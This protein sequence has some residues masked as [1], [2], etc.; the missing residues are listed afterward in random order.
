MVKFCHCVI[1]NTFVVWLDKAHRFVQLHEPAFFVFEQWAEGK[2]Q[3]EIGKSCSDRYHLPENE[4]SRFVREIIGETE[5]LFPE[6]ETEEQV[7]VEI[8]SHRSPQRIY[9]QHQCRIGHKTITFRYGDEMIAEQFQPIFEQFEN[10][11]GI[12]DQNKCESEDERSINLYTSNGDWCI[13]IEGKVV[14]SYHHDDWDH[15]HGAV[16]TEL[17]DLLHDKKLEDW[18]G[19]FHASA[20]V[21]SNLNSPGHEQGALIFTGGSGSGKSTIAA[22][23]MANG[24]RV[25][26]DDFLPVAIPCQPIPPLIYPLPTAISIKSGSFQVLSPLF[27][28][29]QGNTALPGHKN[30]E[31]EIDDGEEEFLNTE[32]FLPL[33]G[34]A[35]D[36]SPVP[37]QAIVFIK[38]DP[39]VEFSL[40]RE[41]NLKKM[42]DFLKQSWIASNAVAAQAFLDWY[43]SLPVYSLVYSDAEQMVEGLKHLFISPN[44]EIPGL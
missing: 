30:D 37:A 26:S 15:F 9:S 27:S 29:L 40:S 34:N 23:L 6:T 8:G 24:Y 43:F 39:S 14:R 1:D 44:P 2:D 28:V 16:Y 19:I 31:E 5:K 10:L 17:L 12:K 32:F 35:H 4:A 21:P 3:A 20:V 18:M 25:I 7:K 41:S 38:Y 33:S 13:E 11:P 22:L 42:N 36:L